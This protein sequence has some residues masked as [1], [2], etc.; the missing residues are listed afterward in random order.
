[1]AQPIFNGWRT[2]SRLLHNAAR[3]RRVALVSMTTWNV[4]QSWVVMWP[5]TRVS[6]WFC[7]LYRC[8]S[9]WR[10][11]TNWWKKGKF[12]V[13]KSSSWENSGCQRRLPN[14]WHLSLKLQVTLV[15]KM[16][17]MVTQTRRK[18]VMRDTHLLGA[19]FMRIN[20]ASRQITRMPNWAKYFILL[21]I[22]HHT[23]SI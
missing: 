20:H 12:F 15:P 13:K 7:F 18:S 6:I 21:F 1:M 9:C 11:E 14:P 8:A 3:T 17:T 4:A 23:W 2:D 22:N 5:F 16:M 10:Q 19:T